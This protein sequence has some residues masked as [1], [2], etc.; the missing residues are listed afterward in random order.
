MALSASAVALIT[1]LVLAMGVPLLLSCR[2]IQL[3]LQPPAPPAPAAAAGSTST[4]LYP[5][6]WWAL[7]PPSQRARAQ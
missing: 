3:L 1:V 6:R 5:A 4:T 2:F 7:L